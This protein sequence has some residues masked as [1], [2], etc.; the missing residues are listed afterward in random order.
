MRF[1]SLSRYLSSLIAYVSFWLRMVS[2]DSERDLQFRPRKLTVD[3]RS[4]MAPMDGFYF[5]LF[6]FARGINPDLTSQKTRC[7]LNERVCITSPI[8]IFWEK[9][10]GF[11]EEV[12][13][14]EIGSCLADC[15][16]YR[17]KNLDWKLWLLHL[18]CWPFCHAH[19]LAKLPL[20]NPL[21][22]LLLT[23]RKRRGQ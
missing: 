9:R 8:R 10:D 12:A 7:V 22:G 11:P 21:N 23:V 2:C 15:F 18:I 3:L 14:V 5:I 4:K 16:I 17:G 20:R 1:Q 13:P 6:Y 19:N